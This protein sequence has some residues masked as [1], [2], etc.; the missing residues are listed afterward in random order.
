[1]AI[2]KLVPQYLNKDEDERLVKPFEM[3]DALNIRVSHEDDGNQGV[4]KNVEGNTAI[5]ARTSADAIPSS[6]T[7][8]VIGC[9]SSDAE[10]SIY[11]FLYNSAGTHG[12]YLYDSSDNT[13]RKVYEDDVLNFSQSGFVKADIVVN[14]FQE[15]LLY[16]TDNRNEPRKINATKA[17][18]GQYSSA[19]TNGSDDTKSRFLTVAKAPPQEP[20]TFA[21]QTNQSLGVNNLKESCFQFAY[22]YVYDDGEVSA[23]SAYSALA[24]SRSHTA[25]NS[26]EFGSLEKR[27]NE[28][29]LTITNAYGPVEKIRLFGRKNNDGAFVLIKE[30]DNVEPISLG[31]QTQE[32]IFRNDGAYTFLSDEEVNK[33]FDA[34][35]R[36]AGAQCVTDGRLIYG[37]YLEGFDN[38]DTDV[39]SYPVYNPE[40]TLGGDYDFTVDDNDAI[41]RSPNAF[42]SSLGGSYNTIFAEA[43]FAPLN[44]VSS[45]S[46]SELDF[47]SNHLSTFGSGFTDPNNTSDTS[48]TTTGIHFDVDLSEFPEGGFPEDMSPSIDFNVNLSASKIGIVGHGDGDSAIGVPAST[49]Q[50]GQLVHSGTCTILHPDN[51]NGA[52]SNFA[53]NSDII[54]NKQFDVT[55][56]TTLDAFRDALIDG[57]VGQTTSFVGVSPGQTPSSQAGDSYGNNLSSNDDNRGQFGG[58]TTHMAIVAGNN[59][60]LIP[61]NANNNEQLFVAFAGEL[62]FVIHS[63]AV[64]SPT[65]VRFFVRLS[66]V[67][68]TSQKVKAVDKGFGSTLTGNQFIDTSNHPLVEE[69]YSGYDVYD[70]DEHSVIINSTHTNADGFTVEDYDN[71][72]SSIRTLLFDYDATGNVDVF[73]ESD[74]VQS[75]KAGAT[76]DFGIV[77]YDERNRASGVQRIDTVDVSH[78]GTSQRQGRNGPTEIDM[79]LLHEPPEWA[80]KWAPVY[81][82]N[83]SYDKIMQVSVAEACLGKQTTFSDILSP[84]SAAADRDRPVIESIAGGINGQIFISMRPTEGKANSYKQ[85]KGGQLDYQYQEGDVMRII[86]YVG[87]DGNR[88]RPLHEFAITS[89]KYYV[90]DDTNPIKLS[91]QSTASGGA[92]QADENNFRRTGWFLTVRDNNTPRFTRDEVAVG[93]DFFSQGCVV[94]IY[95]PQKQQENRIYYEVGKCYDIKTVSGSRTHGGSRSNSSISAFS[96]TVEGELSFVSSQRLYRGDR[97]NTGNN[98]DGNAISASGRVFVESVRPEGNGLYA[99]KVHPSNPFDSTTIGT[100]AASNNVDTTVGSSNSLFPGVVTLKEGDVYMRIRE[101]LFNPESSFEPVSGTTRIFDP[102]KVDEARYRKQIVESESVSD[103]FDSKAIDIGRPFIE[104]VEQKEIVRESAVTYSDRFVSDSS[105]LNLSSFNP[106]LFPFKDYNSQH[107]IITYLVD[108]GESFF[109]LQENKISLTPVGRTLI[110]STGQSQLVTSTDV[111]GKE[112]YLAGTYGPGRNPE[113][114]VERFGRI[115]FSDMSS[116]KVIA[117]TAS[118]IS[119]I[120][121][122]KMESF[123]ETAFMNAFES[124]STPKL[125]SGI[126]PE[127]N[128]LIVTIESTDTAPLTFGGTAIGDIVKPPTNPDVTSAD[129]RVSIVASTNT[130]TWDKDEYPWDSDHIDGDDREPIWDKTHAG[131]VYADLLMKRGSV[132]V[133]PIH[134]DKGD[135]VAVDVVLSTSGE[136]RGTAELSCKDGSIKFCTNIIDIGASVAADASDA[137]SVGSTVTNNGDTIAYST[138]KEFWMTRYSFIPEMYAH[139]HNRFFSFEAGQMYRHNVNT[140]RNNFYGNQ[141]TSTIDVVSKQSPSMV[142]A[143]TAMSIEGNDTWSGTVENVTQTTNITEAMFEEKEGMYYTNIPRGIAANA[144]DS[145]GTER[146]V[147]GVVASQANSNKEITF[148]SRISNLPFGLGDQVKAITGSAEAATNKSIESIKDRKTIVVDEDPGNL[149]GS[150]LLALSSDVINGEVLRDYYAKFKLVNDNTSAIE[151]YGVNAVY[152]PSPL[153]NSQNQ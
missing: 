48:F 58:M 135:K 85:F 37:N 67:D 8:R 13:Y 76:H 130:L 136:F 16:F 121:D 113:S 128:E 134:V 30:L 71:G 131:V 35:P 115:Y 88:I 117:V 15:H 78:F 146:V 133:D 104:T 59:H 53:P 31:T 150:T 66:G 70:I 72:S 55:G 22:Q 143:Y 49:F 68:L 140:T 82:K 114:V 45:A 50:N 93:T 64:I 79:R 112:T 11:F 109:N 80:S 147:L 148:T 52:L 97:V 39:F 36:R 12:I 100:T 122:T 3:T 46:P 69:N 44:G 108:A 5:A 54:F 21:F 9:V 26:R 2:E 132:F 123:F 102:T 81:S 118:G 149:V 40:S 129:G 20:I 105:R 107:G 95:R 61:S 63:S 43:F 141:F 139:I 142:K 41:V 19:F 32:F 29:R 84:Q 90:D 152:T 86:E 74:K 51:S 73:G 111:L 120:S 106:S 47:A 103:F 96:M 145:I 14:Q 110:Q 65:K 125:P 62:K 77:Y 18:L 98:G 127:N 75:F 91:V 94:E 87:P 124:S 27:N 34:V 1:M 7:N 17:V 144:S 56:V 38:I 137:V 89:Y 25:F 101:Q 116:G 119:A 4:V 83:T 126:D 28:L 99:Y 57:V 42:Y 138:T 92:V 60:D 6:G 23:L 153:D 24:V 10:K 33:S 151:L